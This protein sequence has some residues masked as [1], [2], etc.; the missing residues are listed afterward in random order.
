M[1]QYQTGMCGLDCDVCTWR[2]PHNC[3][4]C[5]E[6]QGRPFYGKCRVVACVQSKALEDC[7]YCPELPCA[8]LAE[9]T[10]DKEHG[11]GGKRIRVLLAARSA[12]V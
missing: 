3:G 12:R 11:D 2:I 10:N 6:T 5:K 4:G 9:F 8:L 7:S 1:R